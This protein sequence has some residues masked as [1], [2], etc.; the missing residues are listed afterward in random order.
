VLDWEFAIAGSQLIDVGYFLRYETISA[1]RLEPH[2][3][4]GYLHAGGRL[5]SGWRRLPGIMDLI[6]LCASLTHDALSSPITAELI[7]LLGAIVEDRAP[8]TSEPSDRPSH[9]S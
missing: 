2:F 5:P 4:N 3:S 8:L 6:A 9:L 7:E 1:P